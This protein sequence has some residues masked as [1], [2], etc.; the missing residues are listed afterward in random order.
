MYISVYIL[1]KSVTTTIQNAEIL[2]REKNPSKFFSLQGD[3][4]PF[5]VPPL[6]LEK[7]SPPYPIF[8]EIVSLLQKGRYA[9]MNETVGNFFGNRTKYWSQERKN[10]L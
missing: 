6:I 7:I 4:P 1:F 10:S 3:C 9:C 5:W 2:K 8:I